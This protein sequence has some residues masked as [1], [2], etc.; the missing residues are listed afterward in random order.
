MSE[1]STCSACGS[2]LPEVVPPRQNPS[3]P[4]PGGMEAGSFLSRF[5]LLC[6][7]VSTLFLAS[8]STL[9]T[10]IDHGK[11]EWENSYRWR[12]VGDSPALFY[13]QSLPPGT[14]VTPQTGDWIVDP[15]DQT[16]FFVP[17]QKCGDLTP[18]MWR[19]EA[20]KGSG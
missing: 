15:Q 7:M 6:T 17:V 3:C 5:L 4:P 13:P 12:R 2:P 16:A 1:V 14:R 20:M 9:V 8:C 10:S 19:A 11:S 18:E